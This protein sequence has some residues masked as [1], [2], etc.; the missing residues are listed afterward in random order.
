FAQIGGLIGGTTPRSPPLLGCLFSTQPAGWGR[1]GG[2]SAISRE[3]ARQPRRGV[4]LFSGRTRS[5]RPGGR[6]GSGR[7]TGK[8]LR[9]C[10]PEDRKLLRSLKNRDPI[11]IAVT[12]VI[13]VAA[14]VGSKSTCNQDLWVGDDAVPM[15]DWISGFCDC[16][17]RP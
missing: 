11:V 9:R 10:L 2:P 13:N 1:V 4:P 17:S 16:G 8:D 12:T 15:V 6:V 14:P 3:L 5:H 7:T